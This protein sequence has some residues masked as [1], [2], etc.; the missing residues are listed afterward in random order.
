MKISIRDFQSLG[1]TEIEAK[2]L[3][4]VVG[5]SNLGKSALVR[6]IT[7]A[8][9]N[10][11]GEDFIRINRTNAA[12]TIDG[13]PTVQKTPMR[14]EWEKG[15]NLNQFTINNTLYKKVGADAP[16][17]IA[18]AGYKDIFIGDKERGKGEDIRPQIAGQFDPPFLLGK[19]GSFINDVLSVVSRLGVLLNANGRCAKDLKAAK[20]LL[21]TRKK[22]LAAAE[23]KVTAYQPV[24]ALHAR[25]EALQATLAQARQNAALVAKVKGL[26]T[27]RAA[28]K[29][30]CDRPLPGVVAM[31]ADLGTREITARRLVEA[32]KGVAAV[33]GV[34]LPAPVEYDLETLETGVRKLL[35]GAPMVTERP[36]LVTAAALMLPPDELTRLGDLIEKCGVQ[37]TIRD[38]VQR[39]LRQQGAASGDVFRAVSTLNGVSDTQAEAEIALDNALTEMGTCPVCLQPTGKAVAAV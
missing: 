2:G 31:A 13:L 17:V 25:V 36:G 15:H 34:E 21:T 33:Q 29:A 8:L 37:M 24:L 12:V 28:L 14:I 7:A 27:G 1:Q 4:V 19:L 5:R 18:A 9:F 32:R 10:R 39:Q 22:D 35:R 11:P 30:F 26:L 23:A 16:P 3:T 38:D 20:A 6:A